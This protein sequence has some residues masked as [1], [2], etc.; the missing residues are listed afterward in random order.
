MFQQ[1]SQLV[2]DLSTQLVELEARATLLK[3]PALSDREW[4]RLL[5]Q[6]LLPQLGKQAWLVVA[7]VGGTNIGKSVVFN[8][9]A[10]ARASASSPLAS[11]TRHPVC[12]V[13]AGFAGLH[14][15][16]SVY[17]DFTLRQWSA[18]E[19]ALQET[20]EDL[21][22]WRE[23]RELPTNLLILDTPDIDSDA[24][25]NWQR[26]DA[27]RRCADVLIAVLTQ[28][29]YN[30]AAVK[31]FFR[32]AAAEDKCVIVVF[33]Q[34][35]LPDDEPYWPIWM[36]TFCRETGVAPES[37]YL[38]PNDRTAAN[39]LRLPFHYRSWQ[40]EGAAVESD[41]TDKP[42]PADAG[43][44]DHDS[45]RDLRKDLAELRFHEIRM[46]TLTGSLSELLS[47]QH[48]LPAWLQEIRLASADLARTAERLS[49]E[50]VLKIRNW[51]SPSNA[52]IVA[53]IRQWWQS[54]Q[55]GW[56]KHINRVYSTLGE[57]VMWPLR[58]LRNAVQGEPVP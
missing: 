2:R 35:Q 36:E 57:G 31:D 33:N 47:P 51:P 25:V 42:N 58:T 18:A 39:E 19:E 6:K 7:V 8:H 5:R 28:Q 20:G 37:I 46:Q 44:V 49:A 48:G 22:F 40:P 1:I 38:A 55:V 43:M 34:C 53:Q 15:L 4:H 14:D 27:V 32:R 24:R 26:A 41:A 17:P 10:G 12:L 16:Q 56:A 23:A 45:T 30:D 50:T 21:L 13:P 52:M 11:G 29:K 3:L 54:H 9:L